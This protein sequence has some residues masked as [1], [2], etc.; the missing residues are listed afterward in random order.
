MLDFLLN[1]PKVTIG[2]MLIDG[3]RSEYII[4]H[5]KAMARLQELHSKGIYP[6]FKAVNSDNSNCP[7]VREKLLKKGFEC[8]S[9]VWLQDYLSED[10]LILSYCGL[11]EKI[12][13]Y[14]FAKFQLYRLVNGE[15]KLEQD[16][17]I[18]EVL[19]SFR[20]LYVVHNNLK[21]PLRGFKSE[22]V[23]INQ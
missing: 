5:S 9:C 22:F 12:A 18:H 20:G 2:F 1:P 23:P 11:S 4:D 7:Y 17:I 21:I 14:S 13:G 3:D 10:F 16:N 19:K 8:L 15:F 6:D